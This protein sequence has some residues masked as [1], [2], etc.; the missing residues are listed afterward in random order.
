MSSISVAEAKNRLS[1]L[2]VRAESGE[3][4]CVTRHGKPV[5]RLEPVHVRVLE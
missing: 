3:E 5:A 1:E 2:I 4:I